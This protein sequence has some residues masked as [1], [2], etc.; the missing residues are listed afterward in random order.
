MA[1]HINGLH[2]KIKNDAPGATFIH[3]S[4]HKLNLVLQHGCKTV[5][6]CR[7]F[8]ATLTGVPNFFHQSAKRTSV[9]GNLI[10][11]RIPSF[12]ETRSRTSRSKI[13]FL[14]AN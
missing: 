1:G 9:V 5:K 10:G 2:M 12:C 13:V 6:E 14:L 4:A 3:C 11:R 8:F 7:L